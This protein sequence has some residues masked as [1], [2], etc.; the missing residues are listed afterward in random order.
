MGAYLKYVRSKI[1]DEDECCTGSDRAGQV[2]S[3]GIVGAGI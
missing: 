1:E 2:L 3:V